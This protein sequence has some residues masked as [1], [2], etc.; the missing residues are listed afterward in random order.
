MGYVY[1]GTRN[2]VGQPNAVSGY[3]PPERTFC[4]LSVAQVAAGAIG[5]R[6]PV[7]VVLP[8]D[9]DG[10]CRA[11]LKALASKDQDRPDQVQ[12]LLF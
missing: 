10:A 1:D 11:C 3:R 4:G 2:R 5:E 12:P 7:K 8:H 6:G 9:H